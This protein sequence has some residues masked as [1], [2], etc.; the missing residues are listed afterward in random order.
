MTNPIVDKPAD[1]NFDAFSSG[2]ISSKLWL[3]ETLEPII[4]QELKDPA[5]IWLL[6]GWYGLTG[7]L[8]LARRPDLVHHIR[9]FDIDPTCEA[10]ADL[11]NE[12]WVWQ[13]WKF[14]ARTAD[15]NNLSYGQN[16]NSPHKEATPQIVINTS[17]EHMESQEWFKQIPPNTLVALQSCDMPHED[18]HHK[19]SNIDELVGL[20]PLKRVHFR[21]QR[22]FHYPNWKFTRL[23]IIGT[24]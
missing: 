15:C 22:T 7:F 12:N 13:D 20:F 18:H 4:E 21:G 6:A 8:L 16:S 23:M 9:S 17:V 5:V 19:C 24:K 1:L 14:K 11:F 10:T 2:Q 3:C